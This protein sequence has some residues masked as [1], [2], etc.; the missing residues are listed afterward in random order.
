M[1]YLLSLIGILATL[2]AFA[3]TPVRIGLFYGANHLRAT[4]AVHKGSYS[5]MADG[6]ELFVIAPGVTADIT[7]SGGKV[8]VFYNGKNYAGYNRVK[9]V[10]TLPS[11]FKITPAG[12]KATGRVF[13]ENMI[14]LAYSGR[15]QV[16]NEL[17]VEDYI[18]GVIE[19]ESGSKKELE[20]YKVQAVISRTYALD[21][22]NRHNGEGFQLCDATHCQV[23]HG[24]ARFEPLAQV[25]T[26]ATED[27]VIVDANVNLITAAFHSN[28]GGHTVNSED[29]WQ[30]PK[31]YLV[32][33][34]DT[35][36][37]KMSC[38]NWEK[39]ISHDQWMS[40][41]KSKRGT[42]S[43]DLVAS[44]IGYYPTEKQTFFVD[45]T[46][47]IP[48]R[49]MREDLKL[50]STFF[51]VQSDGEKVVFTGQGFGHGVG[52]CQE[53][54]MRMAQLGMNYKEIIHFYYKDVHLV[55]RSMIWFFK[56]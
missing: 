7:A 6:K 32:G 36:C 16:V 44:N 37:L 8:N 39:S 18:P 33:V 24:K 43:N 3:G 23:F 12:T 14:A 28:C 20:Y 22:L 48:L 40:Y 13:L 1:R 50:R 4:F 52:L 31:S 41:L 53:G 45:S 55:A 19:A 42:P 2:W 54:G 51:A 46:L 47:R 26:Q 21:N 5:V 35:F 15:L 25:A 49:T 11:E 27:I 56:E 34:R 9:F 29:V 10:Q 17:D 30:K 38:S